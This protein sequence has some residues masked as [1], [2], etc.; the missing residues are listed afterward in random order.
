MKRAQFL[1]KILTPVPAT[2]RGGKKNV[3][4]KNQTFQCR[5]YQEYF[6]PLQCLQ[7][8]GF[9]TGLQWKICHLNKQDV[10]KCHEVLL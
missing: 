6:F 2:A 7:R 3:I 4:N 10:K 8:H 9:L 5:C 1:N